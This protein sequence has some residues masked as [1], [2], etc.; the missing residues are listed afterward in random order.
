MSK[1][2]DAPYRS[3]PSTWI[4]LKNPASEAVGREVRRTGFSLGVHK[5]ESRTTTAAALRTTVANPTA[6]RMKICLGSNRIR[7]RGRRPGGGVDLDHVRGMGE[8][9]VSVPVVR[10]VIPANR[11]RRPPPPRS[12]LARALYA[13]AEAKPEHSRA[14]SAVGAICDNQTS[15]Y[16]SQAIIAAL[17]RRACLFHVTH[18]C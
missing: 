9:P 12:D 17:A 4:K 13:G 3:G 6:W 16:V 11:P 8:L 15:V 7:H 10:D 1:L 14:F 2:V 5:A 18:G